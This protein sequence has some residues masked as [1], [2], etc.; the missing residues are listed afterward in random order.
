MTPPYLEL[1]SM[2]VKLDVELAASIVVDPELAMFG[3]IELKATVGGER[4]DAMAG[5]V[6]GEGEEGGFSSKGSDKNPFISEESTRPAQ[7]ASQQQGTGCRAIGARLGSRRWLT[8]REW[9]RSLLREKPATGLVA[10][11]FFFWARIE[12]KGAKKKSR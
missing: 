8:R 6:E 2:E 1:A 5:G 4:K 11:T 7:Q 9:S 3:D 10:C 12:K